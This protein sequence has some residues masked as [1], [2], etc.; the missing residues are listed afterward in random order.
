MGILWHGLKLHPREV[1]HTA[2]SSHFTENNKLKSVR[3]VGY[4]K[5]D[6]LLSFETHPSS[7]YPHGTRGRMMTGGQGDSIYSYRPRSRKW[8]EHRYAGI[9]SLEWW[10]LTE[11]DLPVYAFSDDDEYDSDWEGDD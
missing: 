8:S 9:N 3:I 11:D 7:E 10:P 4:F 1:S 6:F 2:M 5:Y